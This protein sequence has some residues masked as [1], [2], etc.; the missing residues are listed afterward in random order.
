MVPS[1]CFLPSWPRLCSSLGFWEAARPVPG[2]A[3]AQ[4]QHQTL[5]LCDSFLPAEPADLA[6]CSASIPVC[7]FSTAAHMWSWREVCCGGKEHIS[8]FVLKK[9]PLV[10]NYQTLY[11]IFYLVNTHWL[12][13]HLFLFQEFTN[14]TCI[15]QCK[16]LVYSSLCGKIYFQLLKRLVS[17]LKLLLSSIFSFVKKDA[18]LGILVPVTM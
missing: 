12:N 11:F 10:V 1:R 5:W 18:L 2:S 9:W 15:I 7:L 6:G 8:G 4:H 13:I 14:T 17:I 16:L 3:G